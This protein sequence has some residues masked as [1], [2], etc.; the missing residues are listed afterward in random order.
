MAE[1]KQWS[2]K[3][4][5]SRLTPTSNE[6]NL[7]N[8]PITLTCQV[9]IIKKII[10]NPTNSTFKLTTIIFYIYYYFYFI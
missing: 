2:L 5:N 8:T 1:S 10:F 3:P 9:K 4:I 7:V 6:K